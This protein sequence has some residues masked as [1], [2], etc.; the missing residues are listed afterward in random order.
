MICLLMQAALLRR[1]ANVAA[2]L[3]YLHSR[4]VC[5]GDL[6][7]ENVLLQ[8]ESQDPEG[9]IAKIA[10][11]GLSRAL[12]FGQVRVLSCDATA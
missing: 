1:A 11:F 2:G 8:T 9:V 4:N 7:W 6:K 10:D 5:H 3:S 12:A